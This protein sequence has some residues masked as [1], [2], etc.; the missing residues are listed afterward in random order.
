MCRSASQK[1]WDAG[2]ISNSQ[3]SR[4]GGLQNL[5]PTLIVVDYAAERGPWLAEALAQLN[6][7]EGG[8]MPVRVLVLE[9]GATG[10]WW[11][12]IEQHHRFSEGAAL[13][14]TMHGLARNLEGISRAAGRSIVRSTAS[15]LG[16]DELSKGVVERVVDRALLIDPAARPLF[17]QVAT[18][19]VLGDL[20]HMPADAGEAGNSGDAAPVGTAQ[21][22][23]AVLRRVLR[24]SVTRI[25][26]RAEEP[27][28]A[29]A[30]NV[31]VLATLLGGISAS[32][33]EHFAA[34]APVHLLPSVYQR[35]GS[36]RLDELAEGMKPDILGEMLVLDRL[37]AD[38][39]QGLASA[40]LALMAFDS[41]PDAFGAFAER[42]AA[43]HPDHPGLLRLVGTCVSAFDLERLLEIAVGTFIHA[44]HR[45][46]PV[47][48]WTFRQ[49]EGLMAQAPTES[50]RE[51]LAIARFRAANLALASEPPRVA[52]ALFSEALG[53]C[54]PQ[55]LVKHDLL[56]NRGIAHL[57]LDDFDSAFAD[58]TAVIESAHATDEARACALNNR[59]DLKSDSHDPSGSIDDRTAVL[60]LDETTFDRR[61]I[62]LVRRARTLR[63]LGEASQAYADIDQIL[64][65]ED[66]AV[67][68]KMD[69]RLLCAQ[70][71]AEDE[72]ADEALGHIDGVLSSYRNFDGVELQAREL[73][74]RLGDA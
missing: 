68:Q 57:Q 27:N 64:A 33:Y 20:G 2:F 19:D 55:W 51:L 40:R 41:D 71:L 7:R 58:F 49:V 17:A 45:D 13:M 48:V 70:W 30:E 59:A 74:R 6:G 65:T 66:I 36:L 34:A 26:Q 23:D 44:R 69:A 25:H 38:G 10:A 22:R 52:L 3:Q 18:F 21:G 4:L 15:Q 29:L 39:V 60:D 31:L 72:C 9:R 1:G 32:R 12:E 63:G 16:H 54:E 43:D 35:L 50:L 28:A 67:E 24:R 47:V 56:N 42:A 62:A 37:A 8:A 5:L 14:S 53:E 46:A 73:R 61:F 11:D